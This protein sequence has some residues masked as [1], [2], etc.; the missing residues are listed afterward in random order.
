MLKKTN[1]FKDIEPVTHCKSFPV[2][3]LQIPKKCNHDY[4]KNYGITTCSKCELTCVSHLSIK[5]K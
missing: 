1:V 4:I 3:L 5:Y 2:Y